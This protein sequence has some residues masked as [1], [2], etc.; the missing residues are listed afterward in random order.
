MDN[1]TDD[2]LKTRYCYDI[3]DDDREHWPYPFTGREELCT[4]D[5][6]PHS[7]AKQAELAEHVT[8]LRDYIDSCE[9]HNADRAAR[10]RS[11]KLP[12]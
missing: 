4:C 12:N 5:A 9:R 11:A 1:H 3:S 7:Q 2:C 8:E 10:K 6:N